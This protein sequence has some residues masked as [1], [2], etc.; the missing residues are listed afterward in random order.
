MGTRVIILAAGLGRRMK[1]HTSDIPKCLLKLGG[2]T[3]LQWQLQSFAS[4][5][6]QDIHLV[7]GYKKEKINYGGITYH[8]NYD[9]HQ[10]NILNSLFYAESALSGQVIVSYSDILFEPRIVR[11]LI[12]SNHDISIVVDTDWR[13]YYVGRHDHPVDEA[14]GVIFDA[15]S[16][17]ARIGKKLTDPGLI[18]GEFIGMMKFSS[19]GAEIFKTCFHRAKTMYWNAPFQKASVFQNAYLTDLIQ[20]MVD[21]GIRV[22]CVTI[23]RGWQEIDTVADYQKALRHFDGQSSI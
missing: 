9:F 20:E 22:N 13:G 16:N 10:N 5:G 1:K 8:D 23:K 12:Q 7:R 14:E 19:L 17:V 6:I 18:D 15:H 2:K 4:C 3:L 21:H 11:Q